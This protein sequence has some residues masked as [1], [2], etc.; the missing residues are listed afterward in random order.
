M[1]DFE[2]ANTKINFQEIFSKYRLQFLFLLTGIAFLGGA[3]FLIKND[4]L[5]GPKVE[6]LDPKVEGTGTVKNELI[7][8]IAGAVEKP[9]VYHLPVNSRIEDLL[10]ASGGLSGDAERTW[11]EKNINRAAKLIDG[12]KIF[13]QGQNNQSGSQS[14]NSGGGGTTVAQ[15]DNSTYN[16]LVNINTA[17]I[18]ELDALSGIGQTYA[19]KITENRPYSNTEELVS[20]KILPSSTFEK[21]KD[22]ISTY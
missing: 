22:K 10:I 13:I 8:E 15:Y 12:Q 7:A 11:V 6:I 5:K 9:G 4:F 1:E 18:A 2:S 21:I 19:Q 17:S 20:R 16:N 14:A 3:I